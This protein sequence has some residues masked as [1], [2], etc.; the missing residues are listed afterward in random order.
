MYDTY[1]CIYFHP[2]IDHSSN[3][4]PRSF[5]SVSEVGTT[6]VGR[7]LVPL[8]TE[9]L[10][11]FANEDPVDEAGHSCPEGS[12]EEV[13]NPVRPSMYLCRPFSK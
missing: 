7:E 5:S 2:S 11:T 9:P 6:K 12:S 4:L 1:V 13:P 3:G 8:L 10:V